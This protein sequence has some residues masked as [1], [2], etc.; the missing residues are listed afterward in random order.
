M[1]LFLLTEPSVPVQMKLSSSSK[2]C[3]DLFPVVLSITLLEVCRKVCLFHAKVLSAQL[4]FPLICSTLEIL[5][6][7]VLE[8]E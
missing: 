3:V 5:A 4:I 2:K 7:V 8:S 6:L 1:A